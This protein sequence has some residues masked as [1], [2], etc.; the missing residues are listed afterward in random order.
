M[1]PLLTSAVAVGEGDAALEDVGVVAGVVARRFGLGH[2]E[3]A[4]QLGDEQLVV[5]SL[6]P[7][8]CLPAFD[9]RRHRVLL[10]H[11]SMIWGGL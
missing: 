7:V 8:D 1:K 4:A 2:V 9:K 10:P 11:R 6:G 3:Q 5:R